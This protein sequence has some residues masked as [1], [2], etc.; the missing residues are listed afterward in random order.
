MECPHALGALDDKH[1][2]MKKAKKPGSDYYNYKSFFPL[3]LLALVDA[4]Y[5]FLWVDVGSSGSLSEGQIFNISKM[6]K[7]IKDGTLGPLTPEPLEY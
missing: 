1:I 7:K 3:V 6:N 4:D 2:A 5:R